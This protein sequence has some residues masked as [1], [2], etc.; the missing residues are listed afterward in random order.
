MI[1]FFVAASFF[2]FA[3][4]KSGRLT[5]SISDTSHNISN[6]IRE[7][8]RRTSLANHSHIQTRP[9]ESIPDN[10]GSKDENESRDYI[11]KESAQEEIQ[12][13]LEY[14]TRLE[15]LRRDYTTGPNSTELPRNLTFAE[16][17]MA[18][19]TSRSR[20]RNEAFD[21]GPDMVLGG[22]M[23]LESLGP[24]KY[25]FKKKKNLKTKY[26]ASTLD[27]DG[28]GSDHGGVSLNGRVGTDTN[29]GITTSTNTS[30]GT[31]RGNSMDMGSHESHES[32]RDY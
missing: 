12:D 14:E 24:F 9:A 5:P 11:I 7:Y 15:F 20:R 28:T 4:K 3:S 21:E 30:R 23:T 18:A 16:A 2:T 8:N 6:S 25:T 13:Q 29:T 32:Q 27:G 1:S 31:S 26:S 10:S 17:T 19:R 22:P